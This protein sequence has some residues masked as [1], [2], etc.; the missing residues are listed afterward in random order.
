MHACPYTMASLWA[1]LCVCMY[2]CVH[3]CVY[4]SH[5]SI[6]PSH[7]QYL[8]VVSLKD[9]AINDVEGFKHLEQSMDQV[10]LSTEEKYK[11]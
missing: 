5:V 4:I 11:L 10:G 9:S 3:A 7:L 8:N 6:L 2:V 1:Q